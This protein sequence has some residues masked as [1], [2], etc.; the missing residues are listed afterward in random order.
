[1]TDLVLHLKREY[2]DQIVSGEKTE[3]YRLANPYWTKRLEDRHY[4][5]VVL[6][7]GY[8]AREDRRRRIVRSWKGYTRKTITHPH[9]GNSPVEVFAIVVEVKQ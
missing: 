8:P 9:F 5:F 7:C 6:L 3:E 4:D 1:M 2:F